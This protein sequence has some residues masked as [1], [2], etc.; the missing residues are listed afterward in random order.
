VATGV[1][2]NL[3]L[4]RGLPIHTNKG[5]LVNEY[6]R[7]NSP[8]LFAAGDV[9]QVQ[10]RWT[11]Q[12]HLDILWPSA[13]NEGRAAGYNIVD[14]ARGGSPSFTYQKSSPFNS[15]LLFGLHLTVIGRVGCRD[16]DRL[17]ELSHLSRGSSHVWTTPF[18]SDYRSA[19]DA[20]GPN[21][22][23]IVMND[24]RIVG[25]ILLGN[26]ELA[27]PLRR[28]IENEADLS[29]IQSILLDDKVD[30]P[31]ALQKTWPD[32]HENW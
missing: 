17:E 2:P 25:A 6:M 20:S 16:D 28:L 3:A 30:L 18:T 7:S 22:L 15:A 26:Q 8:T 31:Q 13:I 5:I 23:R 10:D 12:H 21:S 32:R 24:G 29:H 4:L 11:G 9:A 27:D 14:V 1:R 19:W